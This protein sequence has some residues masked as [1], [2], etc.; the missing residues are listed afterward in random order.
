MVTQASGWTY[1]MASLGR[2]LQNLQVMRQAMTI[3]LRLKENLI[4]RGMS[5][6][7]N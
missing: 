4:A 5:L 6:D 3:M 7:Q 2:T 1:W